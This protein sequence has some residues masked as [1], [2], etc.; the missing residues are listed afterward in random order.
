VELEL[1]RGAGAGAGRRVAIVRGA[2]LYRVAA[3]QRRQRLYLQRHE[4]P[5][6]DDPVNEEDLQA[7]LARV[8]PYGVTLV[9]NDD[10]TEKIAMPRGTHKWR[11]LAR[12]VI[13]RPWAELRMLDVRGAL[14]DAPLKRDDQPGDLE[15]LASP[16][17][18]ASAQ[19][20]GLPALTG[21]VQLFTKAISDALRAQT[22]ATLDVVKHM[23]T[24]A[25]MEVQE[26][27]EAY[28]DLAKHAFDLAFAEQARRAA[29]EEELLKRTAHEVQQQ[30][31]EAIR[32]QA[33][34]DMLKGHLGEGGGDPSGGMPG[35]GEAH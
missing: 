22:S 2:R 27:M 35:G 21:I 3:L 30:T 16:A 33:I 23:K 7:S 6:R 9:L 25:R 29:A 10:T 14:L 1:W 12:V 15:P 13:S 20:T 34:M 11:R 17:Q 26:A 18:L 28:K 19:Q 8:K 31:P 24:E 4:L 32:E 5:E